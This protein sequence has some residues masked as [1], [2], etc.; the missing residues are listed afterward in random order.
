MTQETKVKLQVGFFATCLLANWAYGAY[1]KKQGV[2]LLGRAR[3]GLPIGLAAAA[4]GYVID[5][6]P[7][8]G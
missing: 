8:Q 5:H 4:V 2:G 7:V 3:V 1:L 6:Q